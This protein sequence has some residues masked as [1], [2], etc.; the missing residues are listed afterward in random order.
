MFNSNYEVNSYFKVFAIEHDFNFI[1]K[2]MRW[3]DKTDKL[4]NRINILIKIF[5]DL[6]NKS[7]KNQILAHLNENKFVDYLEIHFCFKFLIS[8]CNNWKEFQ[9]YQII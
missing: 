8:L 7:N 1:S 4:I 2:H 6:L 9:D 3:I 5:I